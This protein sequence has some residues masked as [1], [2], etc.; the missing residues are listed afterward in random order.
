MLNKIKWCIRNLILNLEAKSV[1]LTI[2]KDLFKNIS[3]IKTKEDLINIKVQINELREKF[4]ME[5]R[6]LKATAIVDRMNFKEPEEELYYWNTIELQAPENQVFGYY[7]LT[8]TEITLDQLKAIL[9]KLKNNEI[10]IDFMNVRMKIKNKFTINVKEKMRLVDF[11]DHEVTLIVGNKSMSRDSI[12][13][14]YSNSSEVFNI[15]NME[16]GE[17]TRF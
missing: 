16:T 2:P 7:F 3:K 6:L 1:S 12:D 9:L 14:F 4:P 17:I 8:K 10:S 15:I 11:K 13:K 5:P